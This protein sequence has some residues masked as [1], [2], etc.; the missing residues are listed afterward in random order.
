[1]DEITVDLMT[2]WLRIYNLEWKDNLARD[3]VKDWDFHKFVKPECG[4]KVYEILKRPGLFDHLQPHEG[5]VE[6][7]T[8]LVNHG[9]DV[10]FATAPPSSDAARGKIE[11]V[12]RTFA[13]LRFGIDHVLQLHDKAWLNADILID[14]KPATIKEWAKKP[15]CVIMAIAH[16]HNRDCEGIAHVYAESYK[17]TKRAWKIIVEAIHKLEKERK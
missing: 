14:D 16:P 1:M 12:K 9:H 7:I 4:K 6:A 5:A 17:D 2:E 13:H 11:W 15:G 3:A 8:D 10:R